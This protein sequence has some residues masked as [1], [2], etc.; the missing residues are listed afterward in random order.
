MEFGAQCVMMVSAPLML[1]LLADSLVIL[2][3]VDMEV[4]QALGRDLHLFSLN[5][6]VIVHHTCRYSQGIG[7]IWL[8][9][10][11]CYSYNTRL[12][13]CSHLGWGVLR[14]CFH[15]EDV[16]LQCSSTTTSTASEL[17]IISDS[18]LCSI[19]RFH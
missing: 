5:Y 3:T 17:L 2:L 12:S 14:S 7:R 9:N 1:E 19:V 16:A 6:N 13:Q 15:S 10:V 8:D 4:L 18:S 11:N